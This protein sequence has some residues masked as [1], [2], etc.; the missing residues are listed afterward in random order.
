[1]DNTPRR[2][3]LEAEQMVTETVRE[4]ALEIYDHRC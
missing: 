3:T 4:S 2:S 1:M